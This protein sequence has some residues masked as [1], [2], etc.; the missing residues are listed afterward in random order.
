MISER[1]FANTLP[2]Q[3]AP[4]LLGHLIKL[5]SAAANETFFDVFGKQFE[6]DTD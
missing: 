6:Y 4:E 1:A 2:E 5:R 3:L